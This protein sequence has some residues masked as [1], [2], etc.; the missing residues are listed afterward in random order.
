LSFWKSLTKP[1]IKRSF[2]G[3]S[4]QFPVMI[5][6]YPLRVVTDCHIWSF[7]SIFPIWVT[8]WGRI[9]RWFLCIVP[10]HDEWHWSLCWTPVNYRKRVF[11]SILETLIKEPVIYPRQRFFYTSMPFFPTNCA[12]R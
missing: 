11:W 5:H 10:D 7:L 2:D 12:T 3:L 4:H 6:S 1:R 8:P 9:D